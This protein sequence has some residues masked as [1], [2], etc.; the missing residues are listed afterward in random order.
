[1]FLTQKKVVLVAF[2]LLVVLGAR[3]Q[4]GCKTLNPRESSELF[5]AV[6]HFVKSVCLINVIASIFSQACL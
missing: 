3:Q 5:E 6:L 4:T 2:G 1:M